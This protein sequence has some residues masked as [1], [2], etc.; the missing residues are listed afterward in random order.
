MFGAESIYSSQSQTDCHVQCSQ[1]R[2]FLEFILVLIRGA[3]RIRIK[4]EKNL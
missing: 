1:S 4:S 2:V 3:I